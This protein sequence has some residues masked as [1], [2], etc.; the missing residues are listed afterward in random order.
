MLTYNVFLCGSCKGKFLRSKSTVVRTS[1]II[2]IHKSVSFIFL[3]EILKELL[4]ISCS[5]HLHLWSSICVWPPYVNKHLFHNC[6]YIFLSY[7]NYVSWLSKSNVFCK[8]VDQFVLHNSF[9]QFINGKNSS[10]MLFQKQSF[11]S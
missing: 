9:W 7:K 6:V 1:G 11:L 4:Q 5:I 2:K 3:F 10:K 8:L